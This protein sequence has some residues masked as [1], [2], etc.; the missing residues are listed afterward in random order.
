MDPQHVRCNTGG[1]VQS[2]SRKPMVE[3]FHSC[4]RILGKVPILTYTNTQQD[5]R[6]QFR[7]NTF[8]SRTFTMARLCLIYA[9]CYGWSGVGQHR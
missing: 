1:R 5:N 2:G 3:F 7:R 6:R 8:V 9:A 4:W